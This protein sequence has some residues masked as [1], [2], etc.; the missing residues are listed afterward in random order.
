VS[1]VNGCT[2][3]KSV[4]INSNGT[5][6]LT[7]IITHVKCFG[8]NTGKVDITVSGGTPPYTYQWSNG[9]TTQDNNNV[10]A[11]VYTVTVTDKNGCT[12]TSTYT[13]TQPPLLVL[14]N[15]TKTNV[16]CAGGNNGSAAV[17]NATGGVPPYSY[18]WSTSP[19]QTGQTATGLAAGTYT[20]NVTD[21]NG[22]VKSKTVNITQ[23]PTMVL[24]LN[25]T[26]ASGFLLCN[27]TAVVNVTGGVSPY[28][29]FWNTSPPQTTQTATGLCAGPYT[30]TV[31]DANGCTKQGSITINQPPPPKVID[32][33]HHTGI[34]DVTIFPNPTAGEV[35]MKFEAGEEMTCTLLILDVLGKVVRSEEVNAAFGIN[36]HHLDLGTYRKGI[37][38]ISLI[39]EDEK[40]HLRLIVE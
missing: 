36:K 17:G 13:I 8:T 23:P 29:Y 26:D 11:G 1:D 38:I 22:C 3:S 9:K 4:T 15:P 5:I 24:S 35:T 27:G 20:V 18:S 21:A 40:I 39:R 30:V 32:P 2:N 12:S 37:Y 6:N 25:K 34:K 7:A 33:H 28:S 16:S 31:T 19:V 10:A 14:P